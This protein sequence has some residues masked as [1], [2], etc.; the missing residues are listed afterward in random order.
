MLGFFRENIRK[1]AIFLWIAVIAFVIGGAYL[2]VRGPFTM[3]DN[4]AIQVG[5]TKITMPEYQKTYNNIYKF[6]IQLLTQIKGGDITDSDIKKLNIKQKTV[7]T[8]IE[9]ALLL[10]EAKKEGIKVT[11]DDIQK[12]IENNSAFF[13]NGQFSK[14]KYLAILSANNINPR[15]YE[16]SIRTSLYINKLKARVLK[17]VVVTKKEIEKSYNENYSKVDL[18]YVY[19]PF[20]D[21]EKHVK[22]G[23]EQLKSYYNKHKEDFRVPTQLK[24][25]YI[26]IGLD[27][28]KSKIDVTDNE[29]RQFY[30]E[31]TQYFKV[32]KRIKV[33]HILIENRD[34]KTNEEFK[35]E[36]YNIYNRIKNK[37]IT[38]KKAAGEYSYDTYTK[39]IGGELGYVTENMVVP[40]FWNGIENLKPGEL[41]KPFRSKFGYHIAKVEDVKKSYTRSYKDVK[42][43]IVNYIKAKEAKESLFI[44]A[45]KIFVKMRD[46]KKNFDD[47]AKQL[48][49][50][51]KTSKYMSLKNPEK[52]FNADI[53]RNS[54]MD[55]KGRLLGPDKAVGGYVIYEV[56]DK[57]VSYIPGF[58]QIKDKVKRAYVQYESRQI[59]KDRVQNIYKGLKNKKQLDK[60][61]KEFNL[62]VY[63]AKGISKFSPDEKM[64]CTLNE[65]IMKKIFSEK[66]GFFDKCSANSGLYV[67]LIY[68]KTVDKKGF[69]KYKK[70]IENQLK[71]QKEFEAMNE[72]I[73]KLKKQVKI[74]IN[75]KL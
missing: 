75:P 21:M 41:S 7:D 63:T 45:K 28:A 57:K 39:K 20:K 40:G 4:T 30:N 54:L 33:A 23:D 46:S 3:G 64:E 53:V 17:N 43:E 71:S 68:K 74:K 69:E 44:E 19:L 11:N 27:Y 52:P 35:K 2:F 72:F 58:E 12:N 56:D 22:I 51:I 47:A 13:A 59:A 62:K 73:N 6:Y 10:Q 55:E 48:G 15:E 37:K 29:S 16:D 25:K 34:N 50:E 65:N 5:K 14:Q 18:K 36:A 32:P 31:H 38:F 67:Y 9:R 70:S 60:L 61:A 26:L 66:I 42:K 1:F 24:F 49:F 8:L